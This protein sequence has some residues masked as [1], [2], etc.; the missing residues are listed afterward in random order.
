MC[1]AFLGVGATRDTVLAI[2][3][4]VL[5]W[6]VGGGGVYTK[7]TREKGA[8]QDLP[9]FGNVLTTTYLVT[10]SRAPARSKLWRSPASEQSFQGDGNKGG[11]RG[12]SLPAGGITRVNHEAELCDVGMRGVG[13]QRAGFAAVRGDGSGGS[14]SPSATFS[15]SAH[16]P[17]PSAPSSLK[18][19]IVTCLVTSEM[20]GNMTRDRMCEHFVFCCCFF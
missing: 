19:C 20:A 4:L 15:L 13:M 18:C 9:E 14:R 3:L 11:R 10:Q 5:C 17:G 2:V 6:G 12:D 8:A 1:Q 16:L 7:S